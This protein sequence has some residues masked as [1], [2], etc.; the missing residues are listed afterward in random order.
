M[1]LEVVRGTSPP[2]ASQDLHNPEDEEV[3]EAF[4][5]IGAGKKRPSTGSAALRGEASQANV[6][7]MRTRDLEVLREILDTRGSFGHREHLELAWWYLRMYPSDE[8]GEAMVQAI[9][10]VARLHGDEQKYHETMTRAWLHFV[11]VH[12]QRWSAD[13]F[14]EFLNRNPRLLDRQ[15]IECFYSSELIQSDLARTAWSAPDLH[16]LPALV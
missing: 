1:C 11:A 12:S 13:S 16:R 7:L 4:A 8:A 6:G 5:A 9:R 3:S 14:E 15:L 10:H 2:A